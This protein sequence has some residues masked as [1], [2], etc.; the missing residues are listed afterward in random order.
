MALFQ[1]W[2]GGERPTATKWNETSIPVVS[3]VADVS[4]SYVGQ[5]VFATSDTRLWRCTVAGS[6]GTWAVFS[7]GPTWSIY[8][9]G[10]QSIPNNT[11]TNL[12]FTNEDV[13]T[14]NMH[15]L[16][17][18]TDRVTISKAGLYSIAMK[19]SFVP[20]ATGQRAARMTRNGTVI[21]GGTVIVN[22]A[23]AAN[24]TAIVV[25]TLFLQCAAGDI[26]RAA[27]WQQA[28]VALNTSDGTL[29]GDTN[30]NVPLF[31]GTWLRD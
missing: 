22:N 12:L 4:A 2:A 1:R 9:A 26:L 20:N 23:G 16:V 21:N 19:G 5:I 6:P 18:N 28:G 25:P 8:R 27:V 13:D 17:T 30:G 29:G 10:T 14:D 3:T 24:D 11:W 31:T 7:G 15:D